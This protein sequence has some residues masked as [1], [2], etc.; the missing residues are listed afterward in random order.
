[1]KIAVASVGT[2]VGGHFGHCEHFRIYET[3]EGSI[4]GETLVVDYGGTI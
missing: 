2:E 4:T 3:A 1:M